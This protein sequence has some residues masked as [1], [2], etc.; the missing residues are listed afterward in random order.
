MAVA[1]M[2]LLFSI[3]LLNVAKAIFLVA[4]AV[5]MLMKPLKKANPKD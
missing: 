4:E 3:A 2:I 5:V 1:A